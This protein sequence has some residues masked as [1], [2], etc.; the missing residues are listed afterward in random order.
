[1]HDNIPQHGH[2][3][4]GDFRFETTEL[5]NDK[6]GTYGIVIGRKSTT[7]LSDDKIILDC[8]SDDYANSPWPAS[9]K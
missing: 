2:P 1:M 4:L 3:N 6:I 9:E 8:C 7:E 5:S